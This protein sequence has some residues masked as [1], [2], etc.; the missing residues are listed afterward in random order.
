MDLTWDSVSPSEYVKQYRIYVSQNDFISVEGMIP[1][2]TTTSTSA[3]VAGL[4]NNTTYYFAVT[5]VNKSDG[6]QK[7]VSAVSATPVPDIQGPE[8][9]DVKINGV[10]LTQGHTLT[11]PATFTLNASDPAGVSRVEFSIDGTLI[12]TDY[13]P[14]YSCYWDIVSVADGSY[15]LTITAFDTLGNSTVLEYTVNV[16]LDPP[17]AP[18]ITQPGN[19]LVT[20]KPLIAVS[21]S[22]EKNTEVILY[23]NGVETGDVTSVDGLGNFSFSLTL[24][25][26]ENQIQAAARNRAGTG[27]MSSTV[28]VTLDTTI[29]PCPTNVTAQARAGGVIRLTWRAPADTAVKGYHLYRATNSFTSISQA[30]R[31]NTNLITATAFD[32]LPQADGDYYYR[33]TT[34]S[35]ADNE[36]DLSQEVSAASD[37]TPPHAVSID[38]TP[39]GNYDPQSGTMAPG[40]VNVVLTVSE[41]LQSEPFLSIVPEGGVPI[42]IVLTKDTD[43]TYLGFFIIS[44]TTPTGTAYAIFSSRDVVGNRG[45]EI[46]SGGSIKI[47]TNGPSVRRLDISPVDPIKN[48]EQNPVSVTVTIGLNETVKTGT[49]PQLSY[50][51]SKQGREAVTINS[52]AAISPQPEEAQAWQGIFVL[53]TDAG[54]TEPETLKFIYQG[55]DYLDNESNNILCNNLFQVY[56]GELPPLDPPDGFTAVALS[57]GRIRLTWNEVQ[58]AIAYQLYR[59]APGESE[60]TAYVRID[61]G[62]EYIDQPSV[63]GLYIYAVASVRYENE[64]ESISSMSDTVAVNSDSVVPG[65]PIN[66]SLELVGNGIKAEWAAPP[67]TE[68]ITY[69][70]YRAD[71]SEITS[72]EGLTPLATGID[73]TEVIDPNPS[74]DE[75]CYVVTAVDDAGNESAPSNSFYLNFELLPVSSLSVVQKD[76]DPPA[77]SWTHPSSGSMAGYDIYLGP[78]GQ[79]VKLNLSLLSEL[80]Y[81]DTGYAQDERRYTVIAVD[82]SQVESIGRSI[83]MPVLRATQAQG[84]MIKRGIMNRLQYTVENFSASTAENIRLKVNVNG[85]DHISESF[86]LQPL[87]SD[88]ISV[89]VGGYGDLEDVEDLTTSIEITPNAGEKVEII[90]TSQIEVGDGMLVLQILNEEFTRGGSGKICFTLENTGKE[91]IEIVTAKNSGSSASD[92]ITYYLLDEDGNVITSKA[93]KQGLGEGV[94]TLSNQNTVARIPAGGTFTSASMD[95]DVPANAPDNVT[96]Q[97]EIT[98]IYFHHGR[99]DQVEMNGLTGTHQVTLVET[100]YYG[101]VTQITP[102]S[103]TGDED[104]VITG[105]ALERTTDTP[106]P[107]I[108]LNLV[109]T[110]DGFERSYE[111]ITGD[112]GIFSHIFTPLE[113]EGGVYMVR[114]VH[115]DLTDRPVH[116]TFTINRVSVTPSS[117][118]LSIPKNYEKTVNIGVNTGDGTQ[119]SNLRLVYEE[120]DQPY[121]AFPQGVHIDVGSPIETLGSK[122]QANLSF[123][124]WADN[125]ADPIGTLILK[126]KSDETMPGSWATI[127]INTHFSQA[128]PALYFTPNHLET[129]VAHDETVSETIVLENKGLAELSDVHVAIVN[130]DGSNAPSW[131]HLNSSEDQGNIAVGDNRE[132]S[133]SFSPTE[134]VSEGIYPFYLRI[135]SANYPTTDINLYVSVTQSGIGNVLFKISDIYTGSLDE[136]NEIVQGLSGAKIKVQN[137][138]VLTEEYNLTTDSFGEAYFTDLPSGRYKCRITAN[139]HQEYIGRLWIKP[140]ITINEEVFLNYNLVTVEWEVNEIVINDKYEIVL[141]AVYETDVPAPVV[142]IEP[143]SV[144]LPSISAGDVLN[145][146]FT[147]T[148]YGLIRADAMEFSLPAD[149]QNFTYELLGG[150]PTSL[151]AK[152]RITIPYRVTCLQSLNQ[153]GDGTGGGCYSYVKCMTVDYGFYCINGQWA[154][155]SIRHCW[156]YMYGEC[157]GSGGSGGGGTWYI[158]GS[159]GGGSSSSPAPA[160]KTIEGVI[161]FPDPVRK[162]CCFDKCRGIHKETF[163]NTSQEVKSSV[164]TVLREYNLDNTDISIKAPGGTISIQRWFYDNKWHHEHTRNNLKFEWDSLGTHI[165]LIDKGGV[166]YKASSIDT[167]IYTHDIYRITREDTGYRW[168]DKHGKWKEYDENGHMIS[169]GNRSG[170]VGKLI[171][172]TGDSGKLIG[173]TDRND[174]QVIWYEYDGDQLSAVYDSDNRRVEY[175]Y[176]D[177]LLTTVT[178]VL[179]NETTYEYD[180]KGRMTRT[181]DAGGRP[182]IISYDEYDSVVSVVDSLGKGHFFEFDYDEAK[183]E[184]YAQ[185]KTSSGMIKEIWYDRDGETQ[186]VNVNGRTVQSILKDGRNLIITDEKGNVTR[187][188]FDEWD[189]LTKVIYTDGSEVAYEYEHTFNRKIKETDENGNVTEYEYD[190]AGNMTKKIEASG[191]TDERITE[192]T[193]DGDGNLLT[194]KRLGDAS[195]PEATTVMEYDAAGNMTSVT[196]PESNVT[197]FTSHDI[198]GNVL[199]KED[200]RGKVWTYEYDVRGKLTKITDPLNNITQIFYDEVG[201]KIREVDAEGKEKLFEY[202][203]YDNLIKIIDASGNE[204]LFEYNTDGKM[205]KQTDAEGKIVLYEYDNEGRLVKTIDG[206]GNEISMEYDDEIGSG[207][208]SCSGGTT[209]QPSRVIY[210]T[211]AKEFVYDSRGRKT[212]EKDILSE[213]DTYETLFGYDL[214]GNLVSKTDKEGKNTYYQYDGLKRLTKVTD[215]LVSETDYTYDDRDNLIS[216]TDANGNATGFEYD[217]NNRLVKEIRPMGEETAYQY[218]QAGNL[219]QKIDAKNQKTE[220]SYDD[221]GRLVEIKYFN[222]GDHVNPVKTVVFTYDKI[223]NLLTYDDGITSATYSYDNAYRKVSETVNYGSFIKTNDYTYYANGMKKIFTGP[224]GIT[225][226]YLYDNANQLTGVQI[227]NSGFITIGEYTWNRPKSMILPGGSTKQFE[228]DPLMRVKSITAKD[229]G[230]NVLL[231]YQYTFDKMNNITSKTTEHGE[232]D[233]G[234]DDLYRLADVDNPDYDD[235]AFTYDGVGNRLTSEGIAGNWSYNTNNELSGYDDVSYVYDD[236]GNMIEKTVAGVV[237]KFFYNTEDRLSEVRDGNDALIAS[238]YYDPFGRRL[239]KEVGGV[240]THFHYADEGLIGEYDSTGTEIKTYGYKPGSTWT[241]DPLFMK[242]GDN[243]Y[244]YHADH[245]GTPQKMTAVNGAVVWAAKY[246]SFGKANIEV[247]TVENNLRF[248]GQYFDQETGLLYNFNR[249]YD[250]K[251]G[252]YL[253]EDP[254]GT[255][256][257]VNLFSYV[258]NNPLNRIDS[259][260]LCAI[261]CCEN[262]VTKYVDKNKPTGKKDTEEQKYWDVRIGVK[263]RHLA[264]IIARIRVPI[265]PIKETLV[266]AQIHYLEEWAEF[267]CLEEVCLDTLAVLEIGCQMKPGTEY[268]VTLS[269]DDITKTYIY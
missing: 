241:T 144:T 267:K 171:Y 116:A 98:K 164:N 139:N 65:S 89:V 165:E 58:E 198:M 57:G 234:Y 178:D 193:Y 112:D 195:T 264:T 84:S 131:V 15:T 19:G 269:S 111:V 91:E 182:A 237:T 185:V 67:Y 81:T 230:Q 251:T 45:T 188:E 231:N 258:L 236:N 228:Y 150:V 250:P 62:F 126:V 154:S 63:D 34:M 151:D 37:R 138:Q 80:T 219:T 210:P 86:S 31:V 61:S 93:F 66:L 10:L 155:S 101:E 44:D 202:D 49:A 123:I 248:P 16:T 82:Q 135:T 29:P 221:A 157:G 141:T 79:T 46:G 255:R 217:R 50:L 47:D 186:Q 197:R 149:D 27:P 118:N 181:V 73:Q 77:V 265:P 187:K 100:S 76:D 204:T 143:A 191:S 256:G 55:I 35:T 53:P 102:E 218:D 239:W 59:Q 39:N 243:Y 209:S 159:G 60:L 32:D 189:N 70:I 146:E 194:T 190:D 105:R 229:P 173:I 200:A 192:Y 232:Y 224:D 95:I 8:I 64:Q 87:T 96:I 225:Y 122:S 83:I 90:R 174:N 226:G 129:G 168:E 94:I 7:S 14:Q 183:K 169:Y 201:N 257:G 211:F 134:Y 220:Y 215:P 21:G 240:R 99:T 238:Y 9:T 40:T 262:C 148:N 263:I 253:R 130:Q 107:G 266:I 11:K 259:T 153:E 119:V 92:Q 54:L 127:V 244:F 260:G 4:T 214:S 68:D 207:C 2:L 245:L 97:L 17:A 69:S 247:E 184:S 212:I 124:I 176:T 213:T 268:W 205:T 52:L 108:P 136:N 41:P 162:E 106:M 42:S 51:L 125:T 145:G 22:A 117:I 147:L 235:E 158:G 12:R 30:Q 3:N 203:S 120:L 6:E 160:P 128:Q 88:L 163:Q 36:S 33:L 172:E 13:N 115:P 223:G 180:S 261:A 137:E 23:H 132:I 121:G 75:H 208:P 18:L 227:P 206:N 72:V 20:N 110:L 114:A 216:L 1:S 177:N 252:R 179:G 199:T 222:P 24:A 56:Q 170:V 26:G 242:V 5:A 43:V 74:P 140:G 28:L 133:T 161:C 166:I 233:Y 142:I 175:T 246:S 113:G 104:I 85:K 71:L 254:I 78:E 167:D 152:E 48:D 109:I 196:D 156:S 38:Y 249:Y 25:E 103:P